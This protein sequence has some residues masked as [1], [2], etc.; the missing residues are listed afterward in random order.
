MVK[1]VE[2]QKKRR[3]SSR[4]R[5]VMASKWSLYVPVKTSAQ[6]KEGRVTYS[7]KERYIGRATELMYAAQQGDVH[8]VKKI[9]KEQV[10]R[11]SNIPLERILNLIGFVISFAFQKMMILL[12]MHRNLCGVPLINVKFKLGLIDYI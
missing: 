10:S 1:I 4:P 2:G 3:A 5:S 8:K 6:T 12:T 11:S 7:E 9:V